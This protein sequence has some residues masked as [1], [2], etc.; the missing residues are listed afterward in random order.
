MDNKKM[1][2]SS[3]SKH[4]VRSSRIKAAR[5]Q[6]APEGRRGNVYIDDEDM[7]SSEKGIKNHRDV[8]RPRSEELV[9]YV[10]M[11]ESEEKIVK[12][13]T[14]NNYRDRKPIGYVTKEPAADEKTFQRLK[15][16]DTR[17]E[18]VVQ[19]ESTRDVHCQITSKYEIQ[20]PPTRD[21]HC[22]MTSKYVIQRPPTRDVPCQVTSKY[23]IKRP[24]TRNVHCQTIINNFRDV[25]CQSCA[26]P[27]T[28]TPPTPTPPPPP[29]PTPPP[30]P[31]PTP[32]PQPTK[33][34]KNDDYIVT[35]GGG[36]N[37]MNDYMERHDPVKRFVYE[38]QQLKNSNLPEKKKKYYGFKSIYKSPQYKRAYRF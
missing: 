14:R 13:V 6:Y 38:R 28:P 23:E 3:R 7:L 26:T 9:K 10:K 21:V 22:Q 34:K 1:A 18:Y 29:T 33:K 30:P 17:K 37:K 16:Y 4:E 35:V 36:W 19:R 20:R 15:Y 27:P 25:A 32:A 24:P 31:T 8:R 11:P 2:E 12:Y 5:V